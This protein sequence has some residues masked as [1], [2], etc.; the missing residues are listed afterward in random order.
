VRVGSS[1]PWTGM[2]L[3]LAALRG[4]SWEDSA[5]F[6]TSEEDLMMTL[7]WTVWRNW[8]SVVS[9]GRLGSMLGDTYSWVWH[10]GLAMVSGHAAIS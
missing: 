6:R 3:L 5:V 4:S 8:F 9:H 1:V 7:V 2:F 10:G